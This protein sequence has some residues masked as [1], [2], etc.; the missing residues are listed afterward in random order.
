MLFVTS[1]LLRLFRL[2]IWLILLPLIVGIPLPEPDPFPGIIVR[3]QSLLYPKQPGRQIDLSWAVEEVF[4]MNLEEGYF[5]CQLNSS[6]KFLKLYHLS[7]LCDGTED[8]WEGSD[9]ILEAHKCSPD[10]NPPCQNGVCMYSTPSI[11]SQCQ[12]NDGYGGGACAEPDT[13][14]CRFQPCS[15]YADCTNTVGS[16][17]CTCRDGYAGDGFF[18][19]PQESPESHGEPGNVIFGSGVL[20]LES[21][22]D[23]VTGLLEHPEDTDYFDSVVSSIKGIVENVTNNQNLIPSL[24]LQKEDEEEQTEQSEPSQGNEENNIDNSNGVGDGNTNKVSPMEN[25]EDNEIVHQSDEDNGQRD[26][27]SNKSSNGDIDVPDSPLSASH[28]DNAM[29]ENSEDSSSSSEQ[30]EEDFKANVIVDAVKDIVEDELSNSSTSTNEDA[31]TDTEPLPV[32]GSGVEEGTLASEDRLGEDGGQLNPPLQDG[33]VATAA[34]EAA[35]NMKKTDGDNMDQTTKTSNIGTASSAIIGEG[36]SGSAPEDKSSST[37]PPSQLDMSLPPLSTLSE[38]S[39]SS[40]SPPSSTVSDPTAGQGSSDPGSSTT[41]KTKTAN[42][43][44]DVATASSTTEGTQSQPNINSDVAA[45]ANSNNK[46]EQPHDGHSQTESGMQQSTA[47]PLD[48]EEATSATTKTTT[49]PDILLSSPETDGNLNDAL[50]Q[51]P[52]VMSELRTSPASATLSSTETRTAS[53]KYV[54]DIPDR[55][56]GQNTIEPTPPA[57]VNSAYDASSETPVKLATATGSSTFLPGSNPMSAAGTNPV[58]LEDTPKPETL[59]DVSDDTAPSETPGE[60]A[61]NQRVTATGSSTFIPGSNPMSVGRPEPA[62]LEDEPTS[63]PRDKA[64]VPDLSIFDGSVPMDPSD[65]EDHSENEK[66]VGPSGLNSSSNG[67]EVTGENPPSDNPNKPSSSTNPGL[68]AEETATT[69]A[70]SEGVSQDNPLREKTGSE[71]PKLT[72]VTPPSDNGNKLSSTYS[73]GTSSEFTTEN[74]D[75]ELANVDPSVGDSG[76]LSSSYPDPDDL[77]QSTTTSTSK[78]ENQFA[79]LESTTGGVDPGLVNVDSPSD[80]NNQLSSTYPAQSSDEVSTPTSV[81]NE[82]NQLSPPESPTVSEDP[83][84]TDVGTS[85]EDSNRISS[86]YPVQPREDIP[87]ITS[88]EEGNSKSPSEPTLANQDPSSDEDSTNKLSSTYPEQPP[89]EQDESQSNLSPA[90]VDIG[91]PS[92][93]QALIPNSEL[94]KSEDSTKPIPNI[95]QVTDQPNKLN[96]VDP[97]TPTTPDSN[98]LTVTPTD[99]SENMDIGKEHLQNAPHGDDLQEEQVGSA[100]DPAV[101]DENPIADDDASDLPID[102]NNNDFIPEYD[103][104]HQGTKEHDATNND[105]N[106]NAQ[107]KKEEEEEASKV[108]AN[109]GNDN[110]QPAEKSDDLPINSFGVEDDENQAGNEEGTKVEE[111]TSTQLPPSS[112]S[113]AAVSS[114]A[115]KSDTSTSSSSPAVTPSSI[116]SSSPSDDKPVS[117]AEQKEEKPE[118]S[119]NGQEK[120]EQEEDDN[121]KNAGAGAELLEQDEDERYQLNSEYPPMPEQLPISTTASSAAAEPVLDVANSGS[122]RQEGEEEDEFGIDSDLGEES[123]AAAS[124]DN[125]GNESATTKVAESS[126]PVEAIENGGDDKDN[127]GATQQQ[128]D[129]DDM[130]HQQQGDDLNDS[131]VNKD[132]REEESGI[133]DINAEDNNSSEGEMESVSSMPFGNESTEVSLTASG[134]ETTPSTSSTAAELPFAGRTEEPIKTTTKASTSSS[135]PPQNNPSDDIKTAPRTTIKPATVTLQSTTA[136]PVDNTRPRPTTRLQTSKTL[137]TTATTSTSTTA[138][139]VTTASTTTTTATPK[140][141][142]ETLTSSTT[143]TTLAAALSTS[144]TATAAKSRTAETAFPQPSTTAEATTASTTTLLPQTQNDKDDQNNS[145]DD[146]N[147]RLRPSEEQKEEEEDQDQKVGGGEEA[148]DHEHLSETPESSSLPS[149][150]SLSGPEGEGKVEKENLLLDDNGNG[151][152]PEGINSSSS[153][154]SREGEGEEEEKRREEDEEGDKEELGNV[155]GPTAYSSNTI[156]RPPPPSSSSAPSLPIAPAITTIEDV[157]NPCSQDYFACTSDENPKVLFGGS[158]DDCK[159]R[160][161]TCSISQLARGA[162][163]EVEGLTPDLTQDLGKTDD[164]QLPTSLLDCILIHQNCIVPNKRLCMANFQRCSIRALEESRNKRNRLKAQQEKQ[165]DN[166]EDLGDSETIIDDDA[167]DQETKRPSSPS[168]DND[169]PNGSETVGGG[170]DENLLP[171]FDGQEE[172]EGYPS[173]SSQEQSAGLPIFDGVADSDLGGA[174]GGEAAV[175]GKEPAAAP[176]AVVGAEENEKLSNGFSHCIQAYAQCNL[177]LEKDCK[178]I[179]DQC[180][181]ELLKESSLNHGDVDKEEEVLQENLDNIHEKDHELAGDLY[182]CINQ[183]MMCKMSIGQS[184]FCMREYQDCS[185]NSMSRARDKTSTTTTTTTTTTARPKFFQPGIMGRNPDKQRESA[186]AAWPASG[187]RH[188]PRPSPGQFSAT[189]YNS[190]HGAVVPGQFSATPFNNNHGVLPGYYQ[191]VGPRV[192]PMIGHLGGGGGGGGGHFFFNRDFGK[193]GRKKV[194]SKKIFFSQIFSES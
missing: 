175:E 91:S 159:K 190:Q 34:G 129:P 82:G 56:Q 180:T 100:D 74:I 3:S 16:F 169:G 181:L 66:P 119:G 152:F 45:D 111:P 156:T 30:Q 9:E 58:D 142:T 49:M 116:E 113:Q 127:D 63:T 112:S 120:E 76:K 166:A 143:S 43:Q 86:T 33:E 12:C 174:G 132:E 187:V 138:T 179:F 59:D 124:D 140:V 85:S 98:Q 172:F 83:E 184:R 148:K 88:P 55:N 18:C 121:E 52:E 22:G 106:N 178:A 128:V 67:P 141:T 122:T 32:F 51:T 39:T 149:S 47:S 173:G 62:D 99:A 73:G 79:P 61:D 105:N 162:D 4:W 167:D 133:N 28:D 54:D 87:N 125:N 102:N 11:G 6:E 23:S 115:D 104:M 24:P 10:C 15:F 95:V 68:S 155:V 164:D 183:L 145:S 101:A 64:P 150:S 48:G 185:L 35:T 146:D 177:P 96:V 131:S 147:G 114:A 21:P 36:E 7:R 38:A 94:E 158:T 44:A 110:G 107:E 188:P 42:S 46:N 41:V 123:Q 103:E 192:P 130:S 171:V 191:L 37:D 14:E 193:E 168:S 137:A 176:A 53:P 8:C 77:P 90:D 19:A 57:N 29:Q 151:Y 118:N 80:E 70:V 93:E 182:S 160:F 108:L 194:C 126:L 69:T 75:P 27:G 154:D 109:N 71:D 89:S 25:E 92:T 1:S 97:V 81:S 153:P 186:E 144:T 65:I 72:N 26:N 163:A 78:E 17:T 117:R 161:D 157:L 2:Q 60:T 20:V 40:P 136:S 50:R 165:K 134:Q 84:F 13:N 170:S 31:D 5:A 139:T 189:P 135:A